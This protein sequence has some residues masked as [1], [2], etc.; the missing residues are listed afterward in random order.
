MPS[1]FEIDRENIPGK[2]GE[3]KK[4]GG[5]KGERKRGVKTKR[6]TRIS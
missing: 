3:N 2:E 1:A 6:K 4:R 5:G